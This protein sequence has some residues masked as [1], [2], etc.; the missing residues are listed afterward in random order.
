M[1]ENEISKIVLDRSIKLQNALGRGLLESTYEC[2]LAYDLEQEGLKVARQVPIP[3]HYNGLQ[4]NDAYR[5]DLIVE[6]KVIIEL[7]AVNHLEDAHYA[8]LT[9]YLR[10]ANMKLGLL[11]NFNAPKI[12]DGFVR[13]A[14]GLDS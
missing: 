2:C 14:N 5:A 10:L 12:K 1:T 8:Q 13:I 9:T 3:I 11:I 6:N 4:I 7:K